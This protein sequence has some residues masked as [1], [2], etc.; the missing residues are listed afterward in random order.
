[1]SRRGTDDPAGQGIY[2]NWAWSW[3]GI[4]ACS[5]NRAFV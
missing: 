2:Q 4:A 3:P 5:N 1:M